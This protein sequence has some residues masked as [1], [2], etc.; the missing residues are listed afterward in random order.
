VYSER[1]DDWEQNMERLLRK[2]ETARKLVPPPVVDEGEDATVGIIAY[3]T[4]RP[5]I[6]EARDRLSEDGMETD[7]MRLRALPVNADV[8][9]FVES[10][11]RVYV[12][13]MNRD[14]QMHRLLQLEMPD[15]ATKLI[16]LSKLD[17]MPLT[18]RWIVDSM[19]EKEQA[20]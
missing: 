19:Q 8:R 20:A 13:E 18:A 10:H 12:I 1:P 4:T 2:F 11:D 15:I 3:G 16:S 17:G 14:G 9:D 5:A 7:F 6:D